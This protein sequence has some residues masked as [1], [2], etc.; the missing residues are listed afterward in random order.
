MRVWQARCL[1]CAQTSRLWQ[2]LSASQPLMGS[3]LESS[4]EQQVGQ[5]HSAAQAE[6]VHVERQVTAC[7]EVDCMQKGADLEQVN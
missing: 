3:M 5:L 2:S 1:V 7:P 6:I 4:A